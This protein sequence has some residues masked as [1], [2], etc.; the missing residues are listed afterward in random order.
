MTVSVKENL[1]DPE[2]DEGP[3]HEKNRRDA[4]MC[5]AMVHSAPVCIL[6]AN[7]KRYCANTL[8]YLSNLHKVLR[9]LI[10]HHHNSLRSLNI[11][12]RIDLNPHPCHT[13]ILR[14]HN[15]R[16]RAILQVCLTLQ[17]RCVFDLLDTLERVLVALMIL[18]A[19]LHQIEKDSGSPIPSKA[20]RAAR[21]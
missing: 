21:C 10:Q 20:N 17:H 15:K 19:S 16:I 8:D 13:R 4:E 9:S 12:P 3:Q 11:Q 1:E 14:Q 7:E 2:D 5:Y 6:Y 18:S